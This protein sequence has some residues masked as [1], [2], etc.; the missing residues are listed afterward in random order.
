MPT[1]LGALAGEQE[2]HRPLARQRESAVNTRRG[3]RAARA[4]AASTADLATTNRRCSKRRRPAL[5]RVG[6][7]GQGG[8]LGLPRRRSASR[9]VASSR[10][11]RRARREHED[12]AGR[13]ARWR[14]RRR[15]PPRARRGRWCR[16]RPNELTPARR[17]RASR[18]PGPQRRVAR[19]TGW[20]RSRSGDWAAR[21]AGSAAAARCCSIS[22]VLIR[23]GD[24]GRRVQVA[25]VGLHRADR[26]EAP[27][28]RCRPRNA[29]VQ[30]RDLDRVAQRGAGP[31]RLDVADRVAGATP[32]SAMRAPRSP[33]P[34]PRRSA[35]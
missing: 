18:G 33:A 10:A 5:E 6:D 3:S 9:S 16:R 13:R 7:V 26:A 14:P 31:V 21:S 4:S 17:G 32:A 15:A 23:P 27:P 11:G 24:A 19:R 34:G 8:G 35:R 12:L 22:T 30:R 29:C 25:D 20:S 28:R 1:V 2:D